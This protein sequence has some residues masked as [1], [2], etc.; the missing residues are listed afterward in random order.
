MKEKQSGSDSLHGVGT[1][2][3][4]TRIRRPERSEGSPVELGWSVF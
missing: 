3:A 2:G 4:V 1:S